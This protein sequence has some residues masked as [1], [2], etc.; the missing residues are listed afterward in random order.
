VYLGAHFPTD[1]TA[2]ALLGSLVGGL[3]GRGYVRGRTGVEGAPKRG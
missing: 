1:V 3:A 2:G